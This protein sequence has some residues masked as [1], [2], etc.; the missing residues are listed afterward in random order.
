MTGRRAG[1]CAGYDVPGYAHSVVGRGF[2]IGWGGGRRRGWR[3]QYYATG[4]PGWARGGYGPAWGAPPYAEYGPYAAPPTK[5]QE[6]ELLK[7][8]AE[9]LQQEMNAI[10][11]RIA[12]LTDEA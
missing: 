9:Q 8:Q 11:Q 4:A 10:S 1:Y 5:D 6:I 12:V 7:M 3:H 2:G